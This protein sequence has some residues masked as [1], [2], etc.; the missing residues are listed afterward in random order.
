MWD[1]LNP[2]QPATVKE[3]QT[4]LFLCKLLRYIRDLINP[5][6]F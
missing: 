1:Q 3:I 6:E 4:V 2:L 5:C